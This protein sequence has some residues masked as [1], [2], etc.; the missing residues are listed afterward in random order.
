MAS[1]TSFKDAKD[2]NKSD[3]C[4]ETYFEQDICAQGHA[5]CYD[6]LLV[7]LAVP[8]VQLDTPAAGQKYASVHLDGRL[9]A[10]LTPDQVGV[11]RR[12]DEVVAKRMVH[13]LVDVQAVQE[14]GRI[15]VGHQVVVKAFDRQALCA[16]KSI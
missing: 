1:I 14:H 10:K 3:K 13:V 9:A 4:G 7:V 15:V 12:V 5:V 11:V 6:W 16:R 2:Q 8:A